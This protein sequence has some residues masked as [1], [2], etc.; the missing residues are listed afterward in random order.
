MGSEWRW[1]SLVVC[2][3]LTWRPSQNL[4]FSPQ[5]VQP[6]VKAASLDMSTTTVVSPTV[7]PKCGTAKKSGKRSCC[8]R[9][10]A[11]FTNCGDAGDTQFEHTWAEGVEACKGFVTVSSPLQ[12][13]FQRAEV[14]ASLLNVS[15]SRNATRLH[16]NMNHTGGVSNA[17][18]TGSAD[19][20]ALAK[21][22]FCICI[23]FVCIILSD[24]VL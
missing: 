14:G 22:V 11:W 19:C 18:A 2:D 24:V 23:M 15:R 6:G 7:C 1:E 8:A 20:V 3:T 5:S 13:L 10:G 17:I 16:V 4:T 9:D 21:V 12:V